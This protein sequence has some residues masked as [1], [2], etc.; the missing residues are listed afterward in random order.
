MSVSLN[1]S[2]GA[3]GQSATQTHNGGILALSLSG[4]FV[5]TVVL[6]RSFNNGA[7]WHTLETYTSANEVNIEAA[8]PAIVFRLNCTSYSSGTVNYFIA[9][10]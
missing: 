7:T 4:T 6:E 2:F 9:Y 10:N 1:G 3:T 5:A 8:S